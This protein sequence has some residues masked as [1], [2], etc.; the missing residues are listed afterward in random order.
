MD[1]T[2]EKKKL[3]AE[4]DKL[5]AETR[6]VGRVW[7]NPSS[8]VPIIAAIAA[9]ATVF[10][11][12]QFSRF[13]EE[14]RAIEAE[15]SALDAEIRENAA[16]LNFSDLTKKNDALS[17]ENEHLRSEVEESNLSLLK[18]ESELTELVKRTRKAQSEADNVDTV[19]A[20][21]QERYNTLAND[22]AELARQARVEAEKV[23]ISKSSQSNSHM[24]T[25]T[26]DPDDRRSST[27]K[28][29]EEWMREAEK[30][31]KW[32]SKLEHDKA[33]GN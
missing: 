14:R 21:A 26:F 6:A 29:R 15:R 8:W 19:T 24:I 33:Y 30:V 23:E 32:K 1:A 10:A 2:L 5:E 11:Q 13:E 22:I 3:Q 16:K 4:I 20:E 25:S 7:S 17:K 28:E 27:A 9:V 31:D 12:Y 18:N